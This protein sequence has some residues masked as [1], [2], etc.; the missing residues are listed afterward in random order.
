MSSSLQRL[1]RLMLVSFVLLALALGYWGLVRRDWLLNRPDNPRRVLEE[2]RIERGTITDRRGIILAETIETPGSD[3]KTRFY[4]HPEA[5]AVVG[6]NSLRY[7]VVGIEAAYDDLLRGDAELT[8]SERLL[9]DLL[10]RPQQ[11]GDVRLSIDLSIQRAAHDAMAGQRGAAILVAV[12]DGD[13][14]AL[15]SEPG[16]DPNRVDEQWETLRD[17]PSAPLINRATQGLYQPGTILQSIILGSAFNSG[18]VVTM[19]TPWQDAL[20][21]PVDGAT[22][23]CATP[24]PPVNTLA[25]AFRWACPAPFQALANRIGSHV[26]D[27]TLEDFNLLEAPSFTLLT[28]SA[29]LDSP[30]AQTDLTLT[31]IGQSALTVSPLQMVGVAAAF[32]NNGQIPPL[33]L[34]L[35]TRAPESQWEPVE[36]DTTPRGTIS[37][38]AVASINDLWA[39]TVRS[40]AAAA[41]RISGQTVYGHAG[42]ALAG[43][44]DQLNAWFIGFVR[45]PDGRRYAVAVLIEDVTSTEA[46]AEIGGS[47]LDAALYYEQ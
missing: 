14:L 28:G 3:L 29:Q 22:L 25:G 13:V 9:N 35:S 39:A 11:G 33:R 6:Y 37:R 44:E 45:R 26:L 32:A 19:D 1:A 46:A 4:P 15:V 20:T 24:D 31:A 7:G 34:V 17:D 18:D 21:T 5:A 23:P 38:A 40:G 42:L 16:F 2:Q 8:P 43:P 27:G 47:I 10:N 41:A 12:P 36:L 30:P